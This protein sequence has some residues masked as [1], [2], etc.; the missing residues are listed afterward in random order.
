MKDTS[1]VGVKHVNFSMEQ[2]QKL[3][4]ASSTPFEDPKPYQRLIERLIYLFVTIRDF[5]YSIHNLS[6]FI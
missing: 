1:L 6:Q 2:H 5:A 4:S 3:V